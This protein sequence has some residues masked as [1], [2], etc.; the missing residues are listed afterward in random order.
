M[1]VKKA[2]I[3]MTVKLSAVH[4][5]RLTPEITVES[6]ELP[7]I[8]HGDPADRLIVATAHLM[9]LTLITRDEKIIKYG[10]LKPV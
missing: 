5:V 2:W 7:G 3:R 6:T 9:N 1:L 4:L 10:R 8:F